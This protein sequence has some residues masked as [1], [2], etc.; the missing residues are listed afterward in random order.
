MKGI[1]VRVGIDQSYGNWNAPMNPITNEFV[2]VPINEKITTDFEKGLDTSYHS[3]L[4]TLENFV[5]ENNLDL[6]KDL[7]FLKKIHQY[8]MHL[9]PDFDYSRA[10][11]V[12][13]Q[14]VKLTGQ[15]I[16]CYIKYLI[17]E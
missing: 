16:G 5:S 17:T 7:K 9:D 12:R 13:E 4:P 11:S 2:C 14:I 3:F 6:Y 1:L 10:R 15:L 8:K